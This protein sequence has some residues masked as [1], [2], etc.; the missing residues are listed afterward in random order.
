MSTTARVVISYHPDPSITPKMIE[1]GEIALE[2]A[3]AGMA[4]QGETAVAVYT[5]M[6]AAGAPPSSGPRGRPGVS[7]Y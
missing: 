2:H 6:R 3:A 1:A 7:R 4:T 5:A